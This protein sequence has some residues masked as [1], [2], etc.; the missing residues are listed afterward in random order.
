M[1]HS[2]LESRI[3]AVKGTGIQ[4]RVA[5][6]FLAATNAVAFHGTDTP[7]LSVLRPQQALLYDDVERAMLPRGVRAVHATTSVDL[8]IFFALTRLRDARDRLSQYMWGFDVRGDT[9]KL[10]ASIAVIDEATATN[11]SAW[12]YVLARRRF[13]TRDIAVLTSTKPVRPLLAIRVT[14]ADFPGGVVVEPRDLQTAA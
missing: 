8:A 1:S 5:L 3:Q 10:S 12:V 14:G 7:N 11:R 2:S 13:E 9:I 6:E 4:G